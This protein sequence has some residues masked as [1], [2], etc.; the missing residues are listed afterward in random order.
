MPLSSRAEVSQVSPDV[1]QEIARLSAAPELRSAFAW[2]RA[3]EAQFAHWQLDLSRI[4]S[5]PFGETAR[6]NWMSNHFR[7]L[8]LDDVHRVVVGYV[9]GIQPG[10]SRHYVVLPA[11]LETVL[12]P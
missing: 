12:C 1:Q 5:P 6:A 2:L 7:A 9:F 4:P 8:R 10:F 3:Q 11:A